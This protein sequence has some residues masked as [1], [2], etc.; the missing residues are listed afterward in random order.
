M[1]PV[2][3][4]RRRVWRLAPAGIVSRSRGDGAGLF[5]SPLGD[6]KTARARPQAGGGWRHV[7]RSAGWPKAQALVGGG[8]ADHMR[9]DRFV[10]IELRTLRTHLT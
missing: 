3:A 5:G 4:R 6:G 10:R 8:I 1:S 2:E 9:A 7:E